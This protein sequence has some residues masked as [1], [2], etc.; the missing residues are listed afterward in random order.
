M[1][2]EIKQKGIVRTLIVLVTMVI[3]TTLGSSSPVQAKSKIRLSSKE[4]IVTEGQ[5]FTITLKGVSS[6][7]KTG[8]LKWKVS[9]TDVAGIK[10][11]S[12]NKA[13]FKVWED[14]DT[15]ISVTYQGKKYKCHI[16]AVGRDCYDGD[17]S[18]SD[19]LDNE[20]AGTADNIENKPNGEVKLNASSIELHYIADYAAPYITKNSTYKY[21]FQFRVIGAESSVKWSIEGDKTAKFRYRI[22]DDGTIYMFMGND[23]EE[24][25]T[26]CTV[27]ATLQNGSRLTAKVRGYDDGMALI[28]QKI[29][30]FKANYINAGMTDYDKMD[31]VARYVSHEYDYELYQ[32]NWYQYIITGSG[33]CMASRLAVEYLCRDLG[34]RAAACRSIDSHGQTIVKADSKVYLVTTGFA[35]KKPRYYEIREISRET[36][37]KINDDNNI[38][39]A[40]FWDEE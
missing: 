36:F 26:E 5:K 23:I 24:G 25:Y 8:K 10:K 34:L 4:K 6:K 40:M 19:G 29:A 39:P 9:D 31:S 30:D 12:H 16:K 37:D 17:S 1:K 20:D 11:K 32:P 13:T 21:S 18:E 38:N 28:H 27:A 35:G 3:I 7:V 33:D 14:G 22:R 15:T 2:K